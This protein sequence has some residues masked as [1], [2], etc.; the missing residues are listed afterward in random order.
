MKYIIVKKNFDEN[1][2]LSDSNI[3]FSSYDYDEVVDEH[4]RLSEEYG[5]DE[6]TEFYLQQINP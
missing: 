2:I 4:I 3:V 1:N 6:Y 5:L